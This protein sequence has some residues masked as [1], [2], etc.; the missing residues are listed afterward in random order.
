MKLSSFLFIAFS[1][2]AA[3]FVP[4][5]NTQRHAT[6]MS[7]S[8]GNVS[9]KNFIATSSAAL[10]T[11]S[12]MPG[13]AFALGFGGDFTPTYDDVKALYALG[14]TLDNLVTKVSSPDTFPA[15]LEGLVLF[16]KSP[17]FYIGYARNFISKSVKNNA[18]GD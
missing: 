9:R 7:M 17:N 15:A 12:S 3:A 4:T 18:D 11:A 10:F 6:S 1:G 14:V 16:N 2:S 13:S 8:K 5:F